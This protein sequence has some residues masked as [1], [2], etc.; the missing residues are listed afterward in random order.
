MVKQAKNEIIDGEVL[1]AFP[2]T[3][4]KVK[5]NN[6]QVILATLKGSMRKRYVRVFPGDKVSVELTGYDDGRGRIVYKY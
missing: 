3:M 5:L 4:F 2:N 6:E 1:E